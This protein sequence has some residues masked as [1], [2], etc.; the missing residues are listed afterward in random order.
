DWGLP[1]PRWD[2]MAS[3]GFS[4]LRRRTR[5]MAALYDGFRIDHVVGYFRTW[6][7]RAG[8][9]GRF[10]PAVEAA[11][12]AGGIEKL[13]A[14]QEEAPRALVTAEDLGL[15]P[16]FVRTSLGQLEL[17]GYRVLQWERDAQGFRD[18]RSFPPRSVATF[19]THD[20]AP[21]AIWWTAELDDAGRRALAA[22]PAFAA[23]AASDG[24]FTP[25]V[26]AALLDGLYEASSTLTIL[27]FQDV[28]G[29]PE[30]INVPGTVGTANWSYRMPW[31]VEDLGRGVP[32]TRAVELRDRVR[33]TERAGSDV[34]T[35]RGAARGV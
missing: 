24:R 4:W 31:C 29:R 9:A 1:A 23:L 20:V 17:P 35:M 18:P 10:D 7:R 34:P 21:L 27:P 15:I 32:A 11:Q 3:S 16:D 6:Q 12:Q 33:R 2:R 25:A 14:I 13:S 22:V 30:R 5:R 26:H 19:G 28:Y 8:D